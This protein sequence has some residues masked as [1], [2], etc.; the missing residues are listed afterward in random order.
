[1]KDK[2]SNIEVLSDMIHGMKSQL[3]AKD[4]EIYRHKTRVVSLQSQID[5]SDIEAHAN[6]F[7]CGRDHDNLLQ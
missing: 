6:R 4:L 5:N 1:M 7:A 3:K 2:E